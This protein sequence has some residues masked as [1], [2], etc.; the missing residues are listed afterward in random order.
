MRL[1][2]S[3]S[4]LLTAIVGFAAGIV[5][6][7]FVSRPADIQDQLSLKYS[8]GYWRGVNVGIEGSTANCR[9]WLSPTECETEHGVKVKK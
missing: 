7:V 2:D 3:W 5:F 4:L 6:V 1:A 8:E 9:R